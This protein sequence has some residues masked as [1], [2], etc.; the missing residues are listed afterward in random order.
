MHLTAQD[1]A[2]FRNLYRQHYGVELSEAV[3]REKAEQLLRLVKAV[4]GSKSQSQS[5]GQR[6]PPPPELHKP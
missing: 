5:G 6:S 3:A 4:W 1:I 2:E